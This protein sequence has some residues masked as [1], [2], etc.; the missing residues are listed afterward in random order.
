MLNHPALFAA[1]AT[2][3]HKE[4]IEEASAYRLV[5]ALR[6]SRRESRVRWP[7][8]PSPS[9]HRTGGRHRDIRRIDEKIKRE[10]NLSQPLARLDSCEVAGQVR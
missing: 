4:L 8:D 9:D 10:E 1:I 2:Q 6:K 5:A 3:H 7:D